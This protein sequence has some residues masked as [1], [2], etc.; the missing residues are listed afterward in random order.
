MIGGGGHCKSVLD[1]ALSAGIYESIGIVV[2]DGSESVL[3]VP[4]AGGDDD[5][6]TLRHEGWTDAFISVGSIGSTVLRR[7]LYDMVKALGFNVPVII[8]PSAIIARDVV[9]NEG[10]FAG[11]GTVINAGSEI[12]CCAI[13]NTGAVI[14]HDCRI[15][16]FS[17]ISPG[18]V[19]C[20]QVTVGNDS[21]IGARSV[22]RQGI[23]VGD[24]V[25]IGVGSVVVRDIPDHARAYGNP[26]RNVEV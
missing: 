19:L 1:C 17:H 3:G 11:K 26:C 15:G 20:G 6:A 4:V 13:I 23:L 10:V 7:K 9:I 12:G 16:D 2:N 5:L 8:D 25:M 21:H 24:N 22:I 18:A 14:E